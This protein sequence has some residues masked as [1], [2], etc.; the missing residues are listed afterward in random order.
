MSDESLIL[1]RRDLDFLLHEWLRVSDLTDRE[2][3]KEHSRET[4]DAILDVCTEVAAK[5]FAPHNRAADL[6]EPFVADDGEVHILPAIA[7][8]LDQYHATGLHT[9]ADFDADLGGLQVP[10]T[11]SCAAFAWFQAASL[12]SIAY[13]L[14]A[15]A[16]ARVIAEPRLAT[17]DRHVRTANPEGALVRDD[18]PVRAAGRIVAQRRDDQGRAAGRRDVPD[19]RQQDVDLRRR[20]RAE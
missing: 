4:F 14:L 11:V 13:P 8:A 16:N 5:H 18:V 15:R 17:P 12:S 1:N 2:R 9:P 20:P 6:D 7:P 19:H 10:S 3:F